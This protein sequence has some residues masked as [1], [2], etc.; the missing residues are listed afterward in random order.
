MSYMAGGQD[1]FLMGKKE[2]P[3]W[4]VTGVLK[5]VMSGWN[6]WMSNATFLS[7]PV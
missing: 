4:D 1:L 6:G 2:E 5:H 3:S 7:A